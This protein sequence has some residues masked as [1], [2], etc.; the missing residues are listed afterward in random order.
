MFHIC[1]FGWFLSGGF[2]GQVDVFSE[3]LPR[4]RARIFGSAVSVRAETDRSVI[5][6]GDRFIYTVSVTSNPGIKV[7][8][9]P[10]GSNL[11][12]FEVKD[13][14]IYPEKNFG[15]K[16]LQKAEFI[17]TI[18]NTGSY[19][20]PPFKV[21]YTDSAGQKQTASSDS[22][23]ITVNSVGRRAS[24]K[25]DIRDLKPPLEL[26][27]GRWRYPV[28]ALVLIMAGLIFYLY[29]RRRRVPAQITAGVAEDL[30]PPWEIARQRLLAL[31]ESDLLERGMSKEFHFQ[32]SEIIRWYLERRYAILALE[33]TTTELKEA[34]RHNDLPHAVYLQTID[35]LEFCDLVKFAKFLPS[36]EAI[37]TNWERGWS[38]I[39]QTIPEPE[40]VSKPEEQK[41]P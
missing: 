14:R 6:I 28:A 31:K 20:I 32:Y 4:E 19:V 25:D 40:A 3:S 23:L 26:L 21:G 13:Y 5:T 24:D 7:D 15:G 11:G 41:V 12:A 17:V 10:R 29:W 39:E 37:R 2:S 35:V 38:V 22:I 33:R 8:A 9:I 1:F 27:T 34:L 36:L 30:R 18:F 16:I